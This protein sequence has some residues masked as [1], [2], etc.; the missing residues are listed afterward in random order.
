MEHD[1]VVKVGWHFQK[2]LFCGSRGGG[3]GKVGVWMA[4]QE[5]MTFIIF[6]GATTSSL[7]DYEKNVVTFVM[8]ER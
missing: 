5:S 1:E 6:F 2:L 7:S 4:L 8:L 3:K